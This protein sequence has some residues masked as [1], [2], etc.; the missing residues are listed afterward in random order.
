MS[1][2]VLIAI[3]IT[4]N[5]LYADKTITFFFADG[6]GNGIGSSITGHYAGL[7]NTPDGH[8][9][10]NSTVPVQVT[11]T[12]GVYANLDIGITIAV[13]SEARNVTIA[14]NQAE[15]PK[16]TAYINS[17]PERAWLKIN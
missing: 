2:L 10:T 12:S 6:S 16:K 9:A 8:F 3:M 7:T 17:K 14:I 1:S 11:S 4:G 15:L 5:I 13:G